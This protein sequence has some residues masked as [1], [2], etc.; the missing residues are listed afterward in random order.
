MQTIPLDQRLDEYKA[1]AY[2]AG[3]NYP[4]LFKIKTGQVAKDAHL[5]FCVNNE[6]GMSEAL[7]YPGYT[8]DVLIQAYHPHREQVYKIYGCGDWC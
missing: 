1:K 4:V 6:A 3:L 7:S 5:F 2:Q 8:G